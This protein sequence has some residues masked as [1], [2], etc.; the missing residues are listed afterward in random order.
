MT[1]RNSWIKDLRLYATGT[2]IWRKKNVE[3]SGK[4]FIETLHKVVGEKFV[5]DNPAKIGIEMNDLSAANYG[6]LKNSFSDHSF[7]DGNEVL[8]RSRMIKNLE[9]IRR[10]R[11]ANE[12]LCKAMKKVEMML[13]DKPTEAELDILLKEVM[14]KEGAESWQHTTIA[15]GRVS[16]PDIY[17]QPVPK[18]RVK[19]GDLVR[20]D[21]GCIYKGY[22]ADLSRTYAVEQIPSRAA[23]TYK[24]LKEA[25]L[26]YIDHLEPGTKASEINIGVVDYVREHLDK[27]YYRGNVGHGVGVELY[28]KPIL[29][30]ED[31]TPLEE[32]MTLSYEVPYHIS[33]LG[34]LNLED[35]VLITKRSKQVVSKY[36][37]DII[38]V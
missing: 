12:I 18:K 15:A 23:K 25:F 32:G 20:L 16:G 30:A 3:L 29:G 4:N 14:L 5:T 36:D 9:E 31:S 34:G 26:K 35:S 27:E 10:F 2:Y 21:V 22:T 19:R 11:K 6:S 37:R 24:V 17:N 8:M 33:G 7:V 1:Q 28:D 13:R 38:L